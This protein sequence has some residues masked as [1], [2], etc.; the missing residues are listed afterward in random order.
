MRPF[1]RQLLRRPAAADRFVLTDV[2]VTTPGPDPSLL[3]RR[4]AAETVILQDEAEAVLGDIR[5]R[6]S[7]GLIAPRAGPLIRRFFALRDQLPTNLDQPEEARLRDEIAAILHHHAMALSVAMDFLAH[8]WRST[9]LA[10]QLD[11]LDDLGAPARRMDE[12][13]SRLTRSPTC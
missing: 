7:L 6:Q 8:E 1:S 12:I 3:I 9:V 10:G 4:I 5:A 13:C 2:Q 11:A